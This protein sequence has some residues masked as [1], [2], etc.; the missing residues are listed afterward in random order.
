MKNKSRASESLGITR[1][2]VI[3]NI[4]AL[5][6]HLGT[7]FVSNKKGVEPTTKAKEIYPTIKEAIKSLVGVEQDQTPD[8][9]E[10]AISNSTAEVFVKAYLKEFLAKHPNINLEITKPDDKYDFIIDSETA[11]DKKTFRTIDLFST[12]GAFVA[13]KNFIQK[14]NI[15]RSLTKDELFKYPIISRKE[16][17]QHFLQKNTL[18]IKPSI[19]QVPSMD[20]VF[21]MTKDSNGVGFLSKE[22][23]TIYPDPNLVELNV[24]DIDLLS[25]KYVCG[26]TR[27]LSKNA[28]T[29]LDG[30]IKFCKVSD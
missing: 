23:I 26:Y 8:T 28:K 17:W 5:E 21:S 14:N 30:F 20:M 7:L 29:F 18:D 16:V 24:Q 13:T 10:I 22:I 1:T 2:A 27:E 12:C 19:I 9:L 6:L 25:M 4:K 3:K 15:Q 11:V